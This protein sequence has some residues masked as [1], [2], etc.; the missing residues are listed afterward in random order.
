MLTQDQTL[1]WLPLEAA[2]TSL[3]ELLLLPVSSENIVYHIENPV[4]QPWSSALL[5]MAKSLGLPL[6]PFDQ[7]LDRLM[8]LDSDEATL[9]EFFA[10]D[11]RHVGLGNLYLDTGRAV[12][13]SPT[14]RSVGRIGERLVMRY[15]EHCSRTL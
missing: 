12:K 10:N 7:W 2:A 4:R 6:V 9:S 15:A 1:S 11:F 8:T 5:P 3:A 13:D 14:L